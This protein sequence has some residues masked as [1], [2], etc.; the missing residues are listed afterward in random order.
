MPAGQCLF[1][2]GDRDEHV[3]VVKSGQLDVHLGDSSGKQISIKSVSAG[4]T[5]TSLLSFIDC[6]TGKD[7]Q[8][9][10]QMTLVMDDNLEF[11]VGHASTFKTITCHAVSDAEVIKIPSSAFTVVFEK[12][13]EVLIRVIQLIMARLQRVIFVALH[14]VGKHFHWFK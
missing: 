6:L 14:Q 12:N 3:Y 1:K 9:Q 7:Q 10:A 2:V 4:E 8:S 11:F 13:P 5:A